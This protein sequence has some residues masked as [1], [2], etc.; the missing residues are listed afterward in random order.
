MKRMLERTM[1]VD[2]PLAEDT[3]NSDSETGEE[4]ISAAEPLQMG[5]STSPVR[6]DE[7][8][9]LF[10]TQ[11]ENSA[12]NAEVLAVS[13]DPA[14]SLLSP[15]LPMEEVTNE[16]SSEFTRVTQGHDCDGIQIRHVPEDETTTSS[17]SIKLSLA[18]PPNLDLT[19][20]ESKE[21][22]NETKPSTIEQTMGGHVQEEIGDLELN[23]SV[24]RQRPGFHRS[25]TDPDGV[26]A[27]ENCASRRF[28]E[29]SIE[30]EEVESIQ[31]NG[32]TLT[33]ELNHEPTEHEQPSTE[34][35]RSDN[36]STE[37]EIN[38][39]DSFHY[40]GST[41]MVPST[42]DAR[43][44]TLSP[45][46][47][48]QAS[49]LPTLTHSQ[50][51]GPDSITPRRLE[52][53]PYAAPSPLRQDPFNGFHHQHSYDSSSGQHQIPVLQSIG[54]PD[55][56]H[57][58]QGM[59]PGNSLVP[60]MHAMPPAT[61]MMGGYGKRKIKLRLVEEVVQ[62]SRRSFLGSLRRHTA[63]KSFGSMRDIEL[64][65]Q[66]IDRGIINVSWYEGTTSLELNEHVRNSVIRKLALQGNV[67]LADLRVL[68]ES[69][70]PP[71]GT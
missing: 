24:E 5:D 34:N 53:P 7:E 69:V 67:K 11:Q 36:Q 35:P 1:S 30:T 8:G 23:Q 40:V 50:S 19:D 47:Y 15:P 63:T 29:D 17:S 64:D 48:D 16:N 13:S 21:A 31:D 3:E 61:V 27:G 25:C 65:P 66:S 28:T 20:T 71:E 10:L 33:V 42:D 18:N 9:Q 41:E 37:L 22:T 55:N 39:S 6:L 70:H 56:G 45:L 4:R 62:S 58:M 46:E 49:L 2:E 51:A 54:F 59:I 43:V 32:V 57:Y 14:A 68:D 26:V 38:Q 60:G 12:A 52:S 44:E